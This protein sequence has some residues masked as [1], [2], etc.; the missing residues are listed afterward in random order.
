MK[1][2]GE[3][4]DRKKKWLCYLLSDCEQGSE[5]WSGWMYYAVAFGNTEE[6][7]AKSWAENVKATYGVDLTSDL[8]YDN[9]H[10]FCSW[11]RI[12]MHELKTSVYGK[13]EPIRIE[14]SYREHTNL[15]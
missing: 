12:N 2:G 5:G 15:F 10:W 1:C 8:K 6:E 9:G 14:F 4:M 11:F 7:I 13:S 3:T